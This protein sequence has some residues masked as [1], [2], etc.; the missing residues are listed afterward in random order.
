[1]K[2]LT[3]T[4][5]LFALTLL[6]PIGNAALIS[7]WGLE[8]G[9]S[10]STLTEGVQGS[11]STTT[12]SGNASPRALFPGIAFSDVGTSVRLS[13][14][15]SFANALGNIQFRFG[16]YDTNGVNTGTLGSGVWSGA[17]S[18]GWKGYYG[19]PGNSGGADNVTGL[20]GGAWFSG[21]GGNYIVGSAG[22]TSTAAANVE[23]EFGLTLTRLSATSVKI[24]YTFVGGTQ[25]RSGSFIDEVGVTNGN[26]TSLAT[27]NAVGF[28]TNGNTGAGQFRDVRVDLL[29][30]EPTS[31]II[32]FGMTLLGASMRRRG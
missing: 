5:V 19:T 16:L 13:G 3:T 1:M 20:N 7:G 8:T 12:P 21:G 10:A 28:L 24:D 29:I 22:A 30:P 15:A 4:F 17:T 11:F 23:Y 9:A 14:F 18:A 26:S 27:L 25:N 2:I 6:A 32:I 31:G